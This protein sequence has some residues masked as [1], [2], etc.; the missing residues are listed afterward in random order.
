[1]NSSTLMGLL[2]LLE[3]PECAAAPPI[4]TLPIAALPVAAQPAPAR[5][6]GVL[7]VYSATYSPTLEQ[8]EYPTHTNYTVA[9]ADDKIVEHVNNATGSFNS[10]PARVSL[11]AGEYHVRAQS[12]GGRFVTV[13]VVIEPN[14]I[15]SVDL[16]S[17]T[18]VTGP[19]SRP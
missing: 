18:H 12:T 8:S 16:D 9:T 6:T 4:A 3:P 13:A 19:R 7:V 1:V 5:Q 10:R 14:K 11:P 15:T 2:L 17:E